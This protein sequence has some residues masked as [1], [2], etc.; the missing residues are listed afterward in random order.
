MLRKDVENILHLFDVVI[1][2]FYFPVIYL[3]SFTPQSGTKI[4]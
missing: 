4:S 2:V 1:R 3:L